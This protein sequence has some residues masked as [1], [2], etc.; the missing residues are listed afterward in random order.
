MV[1]PVLGELC[2]YPDVTIQEWQLAD[3][4]KRCRTGAGLSGR[5]RVVDPVRKSFTY[6]ANVFF[7]AFPPF[8]HDDASG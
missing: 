1:P 3:V 7:R 5:R 8:V 6:P 2:L 4:R